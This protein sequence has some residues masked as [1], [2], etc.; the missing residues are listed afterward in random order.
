MSNFIL[1]TRLLTGGKLSRR[2]FLSRALAAGATL[3]VAMSM[4][5]RA[6]AA[7]PQSGGAFRQAITGGGTTD[8]LDPGQILDMYMANVSFGQLRNNLTEI[9][10]D[11]TLVGELA[12]SWESSPDAKVWTFKLREGV[13]FHNGKTLDANDVVAS[14]NHHRGEDSKSAAKS[15]VDPIADIRADGKNMVVVE[16]TGGSADFPFLL[17]D[18]HLSICPANDDGSIDWESGVGTGGYVLQ[19]FN[20]GVKTL[21]SRNPNYWKEGKAH[22][23][24]I[25]TLFISDVVARMNALQTGDLDAITRVDLKTAHLLDRNP[26]IN[27]IQTTGNQHLTLPMLTNGAPFDNNDLRL[28]LKYAVDREQWLQVI[29]RGYGKVAND[30]PIGPANAYYDDSIEQRSYDPDKA[31]FHLKQAGYDSIDLDLHVA[32]TAFEGATDG[33]QIFQ[34]SAKAA[35]ININVIR[36]ANDGYWSNVWQKKPWCT[37]YWAGRA[38]EDWM[39][40]L[41]YETGAAWNESQWSNEAFDKLLVEA[42][43]EL[44]TNKRGEMYSEMQHL[45][46]DEGGTV[47]P[48]YTSFVQATSSKVQTP[49]QLASNLEF[50]GHKNVERWWF[51]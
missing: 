21:T 13:E 7:T 43:A 35:G 14:I 38:T 28:A 40:S 20:P 12:E 42:R 17:S 11:G 3:P 2:E 27:I 18:F 8:N 31:K 23:D 44:D 41:V 45:V 22:F 1:N 24:T 34:D 4:A 48:I 5:D 6:F 26:E 9:A 50:D 32:D 47:I 16:L 29:A 51:G 19:E 33:G 46:R 39:F 36:E 30:H 37:S 49:E 25:E 10:S 15:I